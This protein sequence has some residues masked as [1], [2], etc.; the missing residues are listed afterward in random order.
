MLTSV[1][2]SLIVAFFNGV[3][4]LYPVV[5][6]TSSMSGTFERGS[7]V[8]NEKI[9]AG[10]AF[11][12]VGE[13]EVIHFVCRGRVEYVHRVIDFRHDIDGERQ[14]I[15]RGDASELTDP[16]PV[17]QDSVLGIVRASLPFF[18]YPYIFFQAIFRAFT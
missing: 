18:G 2:I 8:F 6:L 1:L 9:P 14:Y 5:V 12:R 13:G 17:Q 3:F 15:T 10:E 7:L 16:H 4:P 11:V